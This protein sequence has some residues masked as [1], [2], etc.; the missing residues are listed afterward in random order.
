M[1]YIYQFSLIMLFVLIG[2]ICSYLIPLPIAGSIYGLLLLFLALAF[3]I[4]KLSWVEDT[5]N[6]LLSIM[7]LFFIAPA[8][9]ILQIWPDIAHAW[10]P[11][12]L[13][14]IVA[15]LITMVTTGLTADVLIKDKKSPTQALQGG[16]KTE[17]RK[18]R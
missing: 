12:L 3:G 17:Q 14:L 5:S 10:M 2:E 7:A 4:V 13:L 1:K 18:K 8:V 11:I 6:F 9:A 16:R 15:Y